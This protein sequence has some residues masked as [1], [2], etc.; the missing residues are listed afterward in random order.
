MCG[1]IDRELD[2]IQLLLFCEHG[3]KISGST[4]QGNLQQLIDN[5][6]LNTGSAA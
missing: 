4:E 6:L 2:K 3:K 1:W 5:Q